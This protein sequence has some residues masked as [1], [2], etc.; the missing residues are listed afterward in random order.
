MKTEEM[1]ESKQRREIWTVRGRIARHYS[2]AARVCELH[3]EPLRDS[4][5]LLLKLDGV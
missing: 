3:D 1:H 2:L 5:L 4:A